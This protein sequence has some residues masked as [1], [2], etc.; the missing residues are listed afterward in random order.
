M[1]LCR[2][3]MGTADPDV[4]GERLNGATNVALRP[5]DL[6]SCGVRSQIDA[7]EEGRRHVTV[8]RGSHPVDAGARHGADRKF[9]PIRCFHAGRVGGSLM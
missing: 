2:A 6:T 9:L 7:G 4:L 8:Q 3:L 1:A 5:L